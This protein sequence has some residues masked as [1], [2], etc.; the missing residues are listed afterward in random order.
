MKKSIIVLTLIALA[1]LPLINAASCEL[2]ISMINQDP[3]PA[4][5]GDYVKVVFQID[6]L[7]NPECGTVTFGLKEDY[8]ISL[9][10]ETENPITIQAGTFQRKYSSFYLAPY[11]LRIDENALDGNNPIE[12]FY[13]NTNGAEIMKEFNIYVDDTRA[14][15]EVHIK[16]YDYITREM[17]L[18][19][20]SIAEVDISAL[21]VEIPKQEGIQIK[22]ANNKVIGD[23]DAN[24]YTSADFEAI[25]PE[26]EKDI[27]LKLIYTDSIN[28]RREI[29]KTVHFDPVY[30][31]DRI[32]TSKKSTWW[33][34]VVVVL[35]AAWLVW[36]RVKKNKMKKKLLEKNRH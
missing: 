20:L 11:K 24:E 16:N 17:T 6:G 29:N 36:R 14:D 35:V 1:F 19:I 21:T 28:V 32:N 15:F 30:F 3:Y 33:I 26:E 9:D 7:E 13:Q 18:E 23:L 4:I 5:P 25:L 12:V 22:G 2:T 27:V 8:P 31:T 10:P 34:Y